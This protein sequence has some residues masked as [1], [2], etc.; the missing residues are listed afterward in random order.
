ML[1]VKEKNQMPEQSFIQKHLRLLG[2]TRTMKKSQ[3]LASE[4]L[5]RQHKQGFHLNFQHSD[6]YWLFVFP[7]HCKWKKLK[8]TQESHLTTYFKGRN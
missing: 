8:C 3:P 6:S 4:C 2:I 5:Q 7:I 1:S